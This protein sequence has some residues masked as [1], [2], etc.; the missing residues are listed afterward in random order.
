MWLLCKTDASI[1]MYEYAARE[2]I[3]EIPRITKL[4]SLLWRHFIQ[5]NSF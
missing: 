5:N 2:L 3:I 4:V 1:G